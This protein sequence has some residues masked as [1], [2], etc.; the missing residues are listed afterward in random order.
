MP[1]R[2]R[3]PCTIPGCPELTAVGGRCTEHRSQDHQLRRERGAFNYGSSRWQRVRRAYLYTHP[4]CV[5]CSAPATVADHHPL[6]RRELVARG[7][8]PDSPTHLRPLCAV[9]HNRETAKHQPGGWAAERR[10][11]KE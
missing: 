1:S 3:K 7:V 5:L 11:V 10:K 2:P 4:W 9:C 6:S 8:E